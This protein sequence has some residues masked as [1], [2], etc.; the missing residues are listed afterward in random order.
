[1]DIN[2]LKL[3]LIQKILHTED[4]EVLQAVDKLVPNRSE[5]TAASGDALLNLLNPTANPTIVTHEDL[6]ELQ[7]S[8]DSTF[9]AID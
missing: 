7:R 9:N 3:Q 2:T 1:M 8:I 5:G 4:Q 6:Q